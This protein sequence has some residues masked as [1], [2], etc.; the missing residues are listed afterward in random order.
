MDQTDVAIIGGGPLGIELAV[1]M[2]REGIPYLHF[3]SHQIGHT[4]SWWP[5]GTRW[6]SS[7]ER[8]S[9]AGVPL[10]TNDQSKATREDYLRYLRTVVEEFDLNI[11]TYEP[12]VAIQ[13]QKDN[14]L[15]TTAPSPHQKQT[16][17]ARRVILATGG[18]S[19]PRK[20]NVPGEDLP[21][22]AHTMADPHQYFRRDLVIVGGR[23]S[24]VESALRCHNA[25]AQVTLSY[26]GPALDPKTIK[27][28]LYPEI[29]SLIKSGK[30]RAHFNTTVRRIDENQ[31]ELA[32]P[33]GASMRIPANFIL[34][35]IGYL[36]DMSLAKMAGVQLVGENELPTFNP[37][38][39]ETNIRGLYIA[40]TAIGGTQDRYRI[41]LENCH[42]HVPRILASLTNRPPPVE[43]RTPSSQSAE[44]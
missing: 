34:L 2:K 42:I 19:H 20:L 38:T 25:G 4:M 9:I 40:G 44:S 36:A 22:V 17:S 39:M 33:S 13:K 35:N 29:S 21:H 12:V 3:E 24:A 8:I 43:P 32:Q 31:V 10:Q 14:F 7:N 18:T 15:L 27:Y 37:H 11:H 6:F 28:W 41:F 30:L 23:N 16:Y 26:R 1:A 5:H